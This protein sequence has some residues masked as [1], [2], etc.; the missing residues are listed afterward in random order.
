MLRG[1]VFDL[2]GS[3][4][5]FS[6]LKTGLT[7]ISEIWNN[8]LSDLNFND[9][10]QIGFKLDVNNIQRFA[11]NNSFFQ[12]REAFVSEPKN[13]SYSKVADKDTLKTRMQAL[14]FFLQRGMMD[15]G[16]SLETAELAEKR[17]ASLPLGEFLYFKKLD[18]S[19]RLE[20]L[21]RDPEMR[22]ESI[23]KFIQEK[24]A[25]TRKVTP[26]ADEVKTP[27][28]DPIARPSPSKNSE[29]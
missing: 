22:K 28:A 29:S 16:M 10:L 25:E 26:A 27:T 18:V 19:D 5:A 3:A 21:R 23:S 7:S 24:I 12:E 15:F 2:L 14:P 1:L 8:I 17:L 4:E 6:A 11:W 20:L 9:L 13:W